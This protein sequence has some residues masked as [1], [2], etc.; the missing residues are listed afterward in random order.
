MFRGQGRLSQ[1]LLESLHQA[2]CCSVGSWVIWCSC[3]VRDPTFLAP[4]L[5]FFRS[6]GRR[7]I[8]DQRV[9]KSEVSEILFQQI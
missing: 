3:Q 5:E 8:G 4:V 7:I 2:L 1:C 9:R 6:E